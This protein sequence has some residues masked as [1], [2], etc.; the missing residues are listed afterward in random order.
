MSIAELK[1]FPRR[2]DSPLEG[3]G[4]DHQ[5]ATYFWDPV[6]KYYNTPASNRELCHILFT[7]SQYHRA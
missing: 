6:S 1:V 3:V 7:F 2:G 5:S 4:F